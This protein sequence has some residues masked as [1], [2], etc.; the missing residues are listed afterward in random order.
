MKLGAAVLVNQGRLVR[1]VRESDDRTIGVAAGFD[2]SL[3]E[4]HGEIEA[5]IATDFL[6]CLGGYVISGYSR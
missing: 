1:V 3:I 5:E 2:L 4:H 6:G